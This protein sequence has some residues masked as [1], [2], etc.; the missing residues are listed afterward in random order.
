M[1]LWLAGAAVAV[2]ILVLLDERVQRKRAEHRVIAESERE[3]RES[4]S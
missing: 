1:I 2:L 3:C 4:V